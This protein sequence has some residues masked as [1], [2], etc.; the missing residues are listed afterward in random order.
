MQIISENAC[1]ALGKKRDTQINTFKVPAS[2]AIGSS[3]GYGLS[4]RHVQ[5]CKLDSKE[6]RAPKNGCFRIVVLEK[7]LESPLESKPVILKR[8]QP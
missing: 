2:I 5:M 8:N 7:T 3:Q 1:K 4:S 6:D